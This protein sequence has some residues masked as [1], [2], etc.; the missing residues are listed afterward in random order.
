MNVTP[1]AGAVDIASTGA[2]AAGVGLGLANITASLAA[3]ELITEAK[4]AGAAQK[5]ANDAAPGYI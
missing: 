3:N 1:T 4:M 2:A 5:A